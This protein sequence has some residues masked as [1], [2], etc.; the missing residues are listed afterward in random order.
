MA[1]TSNMRPRLLFLAY[2]FRPAEMIACVRTWNTAVHLQRLG[3]DV[4]VVTPDPALWVKTESVVKVDQE[5]A[6]AGFKR[7]FTGHDW[8]MHVYGYIKYPKDKLS[9]F[10]GGVCRRIG[11]A[12][13][14]EEQVGWGAAAVRACSSLRPGDVDCILATGS[15]YVAFRVA[16]R[17]ATQLNCPYVL[18]YRDPWSG[19]PHALKP[20]KPHHL[21]EERNLLDSC[22]AVTVVAPSW[23]ELLN[24]QYG[25][26]NKTH[27]ISNGYDPAMFTNVRAQEFDH[28]AVVYAGTLYL[29][30]RSLAPALEAFAA[31]LKL[32]PRPMCF[33]Y[34]GGHSDVFIAGAQQ[35][36][37][38]KHVV[39]HGN[40]SRE[41]ALAAQKGADVV[42]VVASVD[43]EGT[44]ADNGIVT[45]KI[46]DCLALE[47]PA[48][49]IAP[50]GS[51]MYA[52]AETTGGIGCFTG[53]DIAGITGF[54]MNCAHGDA[55]AR[56][57]PERY[58]WNVLGAQLDKML[59]ASIEEFQASK[60]GKPGL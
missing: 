59:R 48:L 43:E 42:V 11:R 9:W 38:E 52:I 3:W 40:V 60:P 34:Y 14:I 32:T 1:A 55:P 4:R 45:G 7:L 26:A 10:V 54:L 27:V 19:N 28:F 51:D 30:K 36:G 15:P 47:R 20:D 41:E 29:P 39:A 35:L 22:Q 57:Q 8:R 49:V 58:Q 12:F 17:L 25:V 31:C 5:V 18:D 23:A 6:A 21:E 16:K 53:N 13:G 56:K 37:I 44:L 2:Y 33:H 24:I 50:R 46:F